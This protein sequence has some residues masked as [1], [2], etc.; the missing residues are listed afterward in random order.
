MNPTDSMAHMVLSL[1]SVHLGKLEEALAETKKA[2]ALS[3]NDAEVNALAGNVFSYVGMDAESIE[4]YEK[5]I[6]VNP[7][8]N[9]YYAGLTRSLFISGDYKKTIT[10]ANEAIKRKQFIFNTAYVLL[11]ASYILLGHEEEARAAAAELLKVDPDF[12]LAKW[13]KISSGFSVHP[14]FQACNK[15][16]AEAASQA[17]LK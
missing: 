15:R 16:A 1:V 13:T 12:S 14:K 5:A 11:I 2:V 7:I 17:G 6:K 8:N 10:I 9:F 3:P 4:S